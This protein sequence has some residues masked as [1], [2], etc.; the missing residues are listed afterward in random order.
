MMRKGQAWSIALI[1]AVLLSI[2]VTPALST[3]GV[4][5]QS[6]APVIESAELRLWPEYDDPG[7]LVIFSGEFAPGATTPLQVAFPI[8]DGA[9]NIQA[10]YEDASGSLINRPFEQKDGKL[11][12]E[13]PTAAFHVEYYLDRTPSGEQRDLSYAFEV[14]YAINNLRVAVQQPA[15]AS[16]FAL[17][18]ASEEPQ[19]GADGLTYHG[20]NRS[21]LAAGDVL[22]INARYTKTDTGLTAPRLAVASTDAAPQ[23]APAASAATA[24]AATGVGPNG[25]AWLLIGLGVVLLAGVLAYW[26][27]SQRRQPSPAPAPMTK[28]RPVQSTATT[29]APPRR[30]PTAAQPAAVAVAVCTNCGHPLRPDDRFCSQCGAPRRS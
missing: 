29:T 15:R 11:L 16:G 22:D 1:A 30:R 14:P 2:L 24:S 7:L 19:T 3:A 20:F 28:Q 10:T 26:V 6:P 18:P 25:L 21:N 12:Y 5:A 27:L 8:P 17:T 13:L 4:S 23:A 9:R